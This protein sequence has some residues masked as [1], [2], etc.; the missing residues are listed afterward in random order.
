MKGLCH[1]CFCSC[2]DVVLY[3]EDGETLCTQCLNNKI[4]IKSDTLVKSNN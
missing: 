2:V 1:N 4:N 3:E